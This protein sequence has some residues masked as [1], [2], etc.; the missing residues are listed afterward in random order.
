MTGRWE[1]GKSKTTLSPPSHRPLEISPDTVRFPHSHSTAAG[2]PSFSSTTRRV[3]LYRAKSVNHV[4]GLKCQLCPRLPRYPRLWS[5]RGAALHSSA[6]AAPPALGGHWGICVPALP[7]WAD[8]W[9]R[10]Y[11]PVSVLRF[12]LAF[13]RTLLKPQAQP[14]QI[15]LIRMS[16]LETGKNTAKGKPVLLGG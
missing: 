14:R 10:P 7:G 16:C 3:T 1:A 5:A 2:K 15:T 9:S 12:V 13:S 4:P 6:S 11:G 8:V